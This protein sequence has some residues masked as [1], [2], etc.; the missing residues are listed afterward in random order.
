M[1]DVVR[2]QGKYQILDPEET[3]ELANRLG[4]RGWLML[5]PLLSGIAP[6][7][8]W[9]M[10]RTVEERVLPYVQEPPR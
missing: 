5:N 2:G 9:K 8:A 3:I 7:E 10:L 4:R 6:D 1:D